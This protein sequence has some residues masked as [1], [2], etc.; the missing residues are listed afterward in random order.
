MKIPIYVL[1]F[2]FVLSVAS[3]GRTDLTATAADHAS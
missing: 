3:F 1:G 2:G